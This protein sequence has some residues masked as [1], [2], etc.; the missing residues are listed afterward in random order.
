MRSDA[1]ARCA[2]GKWLLQD[3]SGRSAEEK[4]CPGEPSSWPTLPRGSGAECFTDEGQPPRIALGRLALLP[5]CVACRGRGH[6][7]AEAN[8]LQKHHERQ[9]VLTLGRGLVTLRRPLRVGAPLECYARG[10]VNPNRRLWNR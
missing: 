6:R 1:S 7:D 2:F 3:L 9:G 8:R 10:P 4:G 5:V